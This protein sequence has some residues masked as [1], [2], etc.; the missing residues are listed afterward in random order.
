M[1]PDPQQWFF[2]VSANGI[3]VHLLS[4]IYIELETRR[5]SLCLVMVLCGS[6]PGGTV[7]PL[8]TDPKHNFL[9]QVPLLLS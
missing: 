8:H 3:V 2:I 6:G 9:C 5:Y 4:K 1:D 7:S